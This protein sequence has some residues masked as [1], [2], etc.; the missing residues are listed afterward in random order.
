LGS[1]GVIAFGLAGLLK[2]E[3]RGFIS[4]FSVSTPLVCLLAGEV[5]IPSLGCLGGGSLC[6]D[7]LEPLIPGGLE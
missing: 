3:A 5:I 1:G 6:D 7:E 4:L 2:I